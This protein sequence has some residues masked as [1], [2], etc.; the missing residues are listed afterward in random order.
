[1]RLTKEI[2]NKSLEIFDKHFPK[3]KNMQMKEKRSIVRFFLELED[4]KKEKWVNH[5]FN[6]SKIQPIKNLLDEMEELNDSVYL[7]AYKIN[8]KR[9]YETTTDEGIKKDASVQRLMKEGK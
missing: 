2:M 3:D 6:W 9:I 5:S 1:M 7:T 8:L 4:L